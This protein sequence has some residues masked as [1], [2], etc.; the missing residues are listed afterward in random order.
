[1]NDFNKIAPLYDCL[2]RI[3]FFGALDRARKHFLDEIKGGQRIL[4]LGGGTGRVLDWISKLDVQIDYV[5]P[6]SRMMAKAKKK[7]AGPSISYFEQTFE[8]FEGKEP[9]EMIICNF[10][11]DL[12]NEINL[13]SNIQRVKLLMRP[14]SLLIVTDFQV[15]K[16]R[17]WQIILSK[18]MHGFFRITTGLQ[19][20]K[21]KEINQYLL[22]Q[23]FE[24]R[25]EKLFLGGFVYSR[26]YRIY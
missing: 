1:V 19:S 3:V 6:S 13:K 20:K 23:K 16:G 24:V 4:I 10:F 11:L 7:C 17:I 8:Q 25:K 14:N 26:I 15:Q 5:E 2:A 22:D 12:F 21:L 9:Y 18:I